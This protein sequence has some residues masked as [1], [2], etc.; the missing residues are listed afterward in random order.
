MGKYNGTNKRGWGERGKINSNKQPAFVGQ[1]NAH[2][3]TTCTLTGMTTAAAATAAAAAATAA[4]ATTCTVINAKCN[5]QPGAKRKPTKRA[6]AQ[7]ND[8][9]IKINDNKQP[10]WPRQ[11]QHQH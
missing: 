7:G 11:H 9:K 8:K 6:W 1:R 5:N 3:N 2:A 10:A 4:A